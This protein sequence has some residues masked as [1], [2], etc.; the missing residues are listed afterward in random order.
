MRMI[1]DHPV[2]PVISAISS[3]VSRDIPKETKI[4]HASVASVKAITMLVRMTNLVIR[5]A[6]L[7]C[8]LFDFIPRIPIIEVFNVANSQELATL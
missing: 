3:P 8:V 2:T 4:H 5:F 6:S 7:R 1:S